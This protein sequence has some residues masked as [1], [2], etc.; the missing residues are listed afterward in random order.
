[1]SSLTQHPIW[2]LVTVPDMSDDE[3]PGSW[4]RHTQDEDSFGMVVARSGPKHVGTEAEQ[5]LV[6]WSKQPRLPDVKVQV[7]PINAQSR[8]LKARWSVQHE[9]DERAYAHMYSPGE[10]EELVNAGAKVTLHR[11]GADGT[12][13]VEVVKAQPVETP[14]W[15]LMY[16]SDDRH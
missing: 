9:E 16:G 4:V 6:L 15:E 7:T 5:V 8:K 10:L 3:N 1:M 11:P 14:P 2:D 13:R 12:Q